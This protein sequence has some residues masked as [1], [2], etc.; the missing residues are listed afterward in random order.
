MSDAVVWMKVRRPLSGASVLETT[1]SYL[2]QKSYRGRNNRFNHLNVER[3]PL[4]EEDK[5]TALSVCSGARS[6]A[7]LF[8][9][10]CTQEEE[11]LLRFNSKGTNQASKNPKQNSAHRSGLSSSSTRN[12]LHGKTEKLSDDEF[13]LHHWMTFNY[14]EKHADRRRHRGLGLA[15]YVEESGSPNVS[16]PCFCIGELPCKQSNRKRKTSKLARGGCKLSTE[17]RR[18]CCQSS[19]YVYPVDLCSND[20]YFPSSDIQPPL[21]DTLCN[22]EPQIEQK[23]SLNYHSKGLLHFTAKNGVNSESNNLHKQL[24]KAKLNALK[25]VKGPFCDDGL[26][27][28]HLPRDVKR[29][30][31]KNL[32]SRNRRKTLLNSSSR[33]ILAKHKRKS[34]TSRSHSKVTQNRLQRVRN[35]KDTEEIYSFQANCLPCGKKIHASG[36]KKAIK[37]NSDKTKRRRTSKNSN[38]IKVKETVGQS[39]FFSEKSTYRCLSN[40]YRPTMLEDLIGQS[41]VARLLSQAASKDRVA[42]VYLFQGLSG[43]GKTTTARIFARAINCT[44]S[45]GSKPCG[46]CGKCRA[47]TSGK[48]SCIWELS[49]ASYN[50][51]EHIHQLVESIDF[52]S[53]SPRYKVFIIDEC[54][55]FSLQTWSTLLKLFEEPPMHAVF[56]LITTESEKVP[57]NVV[58]RCQ[59]LQFLRIKHSDIVSRLESIAN[60]ENIFTEPGVLDLIASKANGSL[61]DAETLLDQLSLLDQRIVSATFHKL[62]GSV[63]DE[64]LM[65]LLNSA[66]SSD[67]VSIV[68]KT[69]EIIGLGVD[70]LELISELEALVINILAGRYV[71]MEIGRNDEYLLAHAWSDVEKQKLRTA[72]QLL[73]ETE[74]QVRRVSLFKVIWLIMALLQ[75]GSMFQSKATHGGATTKFMPVTR[76]TPKRTKQRTRRGPE[77]NLLPKARGGESDS[78]FES[79]IEDPA[80]QV[81]LRSMT[82]HASHSTVLGDAFMSNLE[83]QSLINNG[84]NIHQKSPM[85]L[86]DL[87]QNV[88]NI[89]RPI[90]L[91]NFLQNHSRLISLSLS[92]VNVVAHLVFVK[93]AD[94]ITAETHRARILESFKEVLGPYVKVQLHLASGLCRAGLIEE[95]SAESDTVS[96]EIQTCWEGSDCRDEKASSDVKLRNAEVDISQN[97]SFLIDAVRS[98]GNNTSFPSWSVARARITVDGQHTSSNIIH[99]SNRH[100]VKASDHSLPAN[101]GCPIADWCSLVQTP[102]NGGLYM[103]CCLHLKKR[104]KTNGWKVVRLHARKYLHDCFSTKS[105]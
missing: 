34:A 52:T 10:I 69:R 49:A 4:V 88:V 6:D 51:I 21:F 92:A 62:V 9:G 84:I 26:N 93:P 16:L 47:L 39:N 95:S 27:G 15:S 105:R 46:L 73:L 7:L 102:L 103:A 42:P 37:A 65:S 61:R 104:V 22:P 30:E 98:C 55:V 12:F 83:E 68:Q 53:R 85:N 78:A 54:H 100:S 36:M 29:M 67:A 25:N 50:G 33:Y 2:N 48:A 86:G 101:S 96:S 5:K 76:S 45:G 77:G 23:R 97:P 74:V 81:S 56:I 40:K 14:N 24:G 38:I 66:M 20:H 43:T 75:L 8:E 58:S 31:H 41:L 94:T 60:F 19:I 3:L 89:C 28:S 44:S 64:K 72:L 1:N 11:N 63:S 99:L 18:P 91:S 57:L 80:R 79:G 71:A 70:P 82:D 32:F 17:C 35:R 59:R 90:S 13:S 87:W